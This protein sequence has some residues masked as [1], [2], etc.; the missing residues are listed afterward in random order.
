MRT[1]DAQE[2]LFEACRAGDL[3][4]VEL[5]AAQGVNINA[6]T[7]DGET[8][9]LLSLKARKS[10]VA[11]RLLRC[12]ANVSLANCIGHA[13]LHIA[14]HNNAPD[15]VRD[16]IANGAN[17]SVVDSLGRTPLHFAAQTNAH[18]VVGPLVDAGALIDQKCDKKTNA[19]H[20]AAHEGDTKKEFVQ[21]LLRH[22]ASLGAT[23]AFGQTPLHIS[24]SRKQEG[25]C[26]IFMMAGANINARDN[27][28]QSPLHAAARSLDRS[29]CLLLLNAGTDANA[30]D[31]LGQTPMA[32]TNSFGVELALRAWG[33]FG[34]KSS[35]SAPT[36][37]EMMISCA[38]SGQAERLV[39]LLE[40]EGAANDKDLL[41]ELT[42]QARPLGHYNVIAS[43]QAL[44]ARNLLMSL[45]PGRHIIPQA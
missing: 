26:K 34:G 21:E 43:L 19:L 8:P 36:M 17:A 12:G 22:G 16:L 45:L 37:Q 35:P 29:I 44:S 4:R 13:P 28:N 24:A 38:C 40:Q 20:V 6:Q 25:L 3:A 15:L 33:G 9:L 23:D 31:D 27:L 1:P 11:K 39:S 10:S 41:C 30:R 2:D 42:E 18:L 7:K 32:C 14:A 5:L